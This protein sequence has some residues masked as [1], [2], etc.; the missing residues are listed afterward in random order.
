MFN[1]RAAERYV[2][3]FLKRGLDSTAGPMV[4]ALRSQG[5]QAASVMEI[6]AG[7]GTAVVSMLE[8]GAS[9]ATAFEISPAYEAPA[10]RLF[11]A[12]GISAPI[13]WNTGD[14]VAIGG[15]A[16]EADVVFMNRVVCCYPDMADLV[17]AAGSKSNRLLAMSY[18]RDRWLFRLFVRIG[19]AWLRFRR[20]S[21]RVFIHDPDAVAARVETAG[22]REIASGTTPGW[23]WKVWERVAVGQ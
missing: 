16:P 8:A 19:N 22:L 13:D 15:E 6:G 9:R 18:P 12:R 3:S 1:K 23:H 7:A 17:D 21:F 10:H 11:A 5:L 14:F 20:N 4:E 2:R